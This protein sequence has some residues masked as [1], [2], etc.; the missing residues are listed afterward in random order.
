MLYIHY[1]YSLYGIN[2]CNYFVINVGTVDT[3]WTTPPTASDYDLFGSR[4]VGLIWSESNQK[5]QLLGTT[6]PHTSLVVPN[7]NQILDLEVGKIVQE[8][9]E[10]CIYY[11]GTHG[12]DTNTGFHIIEAKL[13][14]GGALAAAI[15]ETPSV[16]NQITII[17]FDNCSYTENNTIPSWIHVHAQ[18]ASL[19]GTISI[20]D[21]SSVH[22]AS[23]TVSAGN[24][25][26][27]S[28]G[29]SIVTINKMNL[30]GNADGVLNTGT[31]LT[32]RSDIISVDS[33]VAFTNNSAGSSNVDIKT[34]NTLATSVAI[35]ELAGTINGT[36]GQILGA[37]LAFNVIGT[38]NV[39]ASNINT[40]LAYNIAAT[41]V[42]NLY[43][44]SI[45]GTQVIALGGIA[46]VLPAGLLTT[47]GDLY[48]RE[49]VGTDNKI[50]RFPSSVD[51]TI[52]YSDSTQSTG[53]RWG[54]APAGGSSEK[55]ITISSMQIIAYSLNPLPIGY[56]D[57]VNHKY[58][59]SIRTIHYES[60]VPVGKSLTVSIYNESIDPT[61]TTPLGTQ[62][63]VGPLSYPNTFKDFT[64]TRPGGSSSFTGSIS[65]TTLTVTAIGSGSISVGQSISGGSILSG[66][67]IVNQLVGTT[68]TV[69]LSQTVGSSAI[70]GSGADAR[71]AICVSKTPVGGVNPTVDNCLYLGRSKNICGIK[72]NVVTTTSAA[73]PL[74]S[75]EW[76]YWNGTTWVE[77]LVM[78]T[79][80]E[81]PYYYVD[82]C[83]VSE[84]NTYHIRFGIKSNDPFV[85]KEINGVT[86]KW[87]RVRIKEALVSMPQT[88]YVKFHTNS[89]K[90]NKDGF[91]EYFGDSRTIKKLNWDLHGFDHNNNNIGDQSLFYSKVLGVH[92]ER[93]QFPSSILSRLCLATFIPTDIDN[94]FPVKLKFAIIGDSATS[95]DV[96]LTF[97][98]DFSSKDSAVYTDI[99]DAP[100]NT[101]S[102]KSVSTVVTVAAKDNEYRAE[103]SLMLDSIDANL[104]VGGPQMVWISIER[105]AGVG[106]DTYTG[107]LS[108]IQLVPF[109][110][111]WID[112]GHLLGY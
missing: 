32:F 11:V 76:T 56:F 62:T 109:Y 63:L 93:N 41:G 95:G 10:E 85:A 26:I 42:L 24:I 60:F 14:F 96:E 89:V 70:T 73:T 66:T 104:Y 39:N 57:W 38:I 105:N 69:N 43:T 28:S 9:A 71:L 91:T 34:I 50:V 37:G 80:N 72:I 83:F 4:Q 25:G 46:N 31:N 59:G 64:F 88:E 47:K 68:Y 29:T 36:I 99:A 65:G 90:I 3:N 106:S 17:C 2:I 107:N 55:N 7:A 54:V 20:A 111:S 6:L 45:N 94:S 102:E 35:S 97:R 15:A 23:Q 5:M 112:G 67:Y 101:T 77:F 103:V 92:C 44:G 51:G 22:F 1:M 84:V 100:A 110:I 82:T 53:L 49:I 40:P 21:Q 108:M 86:T 19:I 16:S 98:Y 8:L 79:K 48:T 61:Y 52:L 12:D 75:L 87:V 74:S 33:G 27:T 81:A 78:Q 30:S 13:T 18:S 58:T